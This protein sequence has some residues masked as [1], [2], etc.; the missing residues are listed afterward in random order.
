MNKL[1]VLLFSLCLLGLTLPQDAVRASTLRGFGS[2]QASALPAGAGMKF[3]CDSPAHAVLLIHKLA[4]D[5]ALSATVPSHWTMVSVGGASVPVLVRPGLGAYLVL[6]QG[7][8]AYCF[9]APLNAGQTEDGLAAAF[10]G[11]APLVPGAQLYDASYTYP[12]YLDKWTDKGIGTW[13]IPDDPFGDD[14]PELKDIINPH[15]Q[16][17]TKN[18]L[19]VHMGDGTRGVTMH[20]IRKYNRPYHFARWLRWDDDI[21]RL[22]PFELALPG[23]WFTSTSDYYG[24]VSNSGTKLQQYRNW[25]FQN[26]MT[27]YVNDPNLVDWDEPHGEFSVGG[28]QANG[29][30]SESS[31]LTFVHWL[32]TK[33]G[34]TLASLGQAWHHDPHFFA[35][36]SRVPLPNDYSLFGAEPDSVFSDHTWRIHSADVPTGVAAGFARSTFDDRRWFSLQLPGGEVGGLFRYIY[37]P[38]WYR[39]TITVTPAYLAAHKNA[40][41]L[42]IASLTEAQGPKSPDQVWFNGVDLGGMSGPGGSGITGTKDVTGIVHAGVNHIAYKPARDYMAGTFFLASKPMDRYPHRDSGVNARSVDWS[43]YLTDKAVDQDEDTLK[44]IRGTDP[45]RPIKSMAT[46]DKSAY[47]PMLADYA[48]FGHNTGDEAFFFPW[49]KRFGYPYGMHASAESSG[50]MVD[51]VAYNR[52]F[53]WFIFSG[54]NAFDNFIDVEAMMYTKVT[55][56]WQQNFPYLHL[57]NRYNL[58]K[59]AIGLLWSGSNSR[60][61]S[62]ESGSTP[63]VF[64]LGRGDLESIGYSYAYLDE[65]GLKRHLAD[66]YK[67]LWDCSTN[68]M[69]CETVSDLRHYVEQGGTF[70]ALQ[71]TGRNTPTE[72]DAWPIEAL[73]GFHVKQIRPMGGF[74]SILPDQ[75]L[76]KTL[77]GQNFQNEGRSTDYSGYNFADKCL[78]LEPVVPGTQVIARYRDGAIAIGMRKLGKGRVIV[79]GSP[80]WRDSY[81][82]AGMWWPG[83]GQNA[84]LQDLLTGLGLPP[85]VPADTQKV[86]RDRYIANNGTEEYLLL[87]N[88]DDKAPQTLTADWN[89][90]FPLTQVFDPKTGTVVAAKIDGSTAHVT[91]TLQPL[92]TKILAVQS[93]AAPVGT[94]SAWYTDLAVTWRQSRPGRTVTYPK[95]LPVYYADFSAAGGKVVEE[96]SVTP[97]R[98]TTLT[99]NPD[100]ETGWDPALDNTRPQPAEIPITPTQTALDRYA[101]TVPPSWQPGDTYYLRA[102]N[103]GKQAYL[104]GKPVPDG[105]EN[106]R[107][108]SS[109]LNFTGPNTLVIDTNV[110]AY[111]GGASLW[112]QPHAVSKLSLAGPWNVW[113]DE[114]HGLVKTPLPGSFNG[115][116]ATRTITVPAAWRSSHVF[117]RLKW[118]GGAQPG[119]LAVNSKVLFFDTDRPG[120]MDV[121]PWLKFGGPNTFLIQSRS[122]NDWQPGKVTILSAQLEQVPHV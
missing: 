67:V 117:L 38:L 43:D 21:A 41:S 108:V 5:M 97:E 122:M 78:A 10:A 13:Y 93:T 96:A 118:D 103:I 25:D 22:D 77:A 113:V 54:L 48:A 106:G 61:P 89:A 62:G 33:R 70:V 95:G 58:K 56:L 79:L 35:D 4:H 24:Q 37:K 75:P 15:F 57:A 91:E 121:T 46:G 36:W 65:T 76:F 20:Y 49:D 2:V 81:D 12:F 51:P 34:Y 116:L 112:R 40:V 50:S 120:Y 88:P 69:P 102:G 9:T 74:V 119:Y 92:E 73:T 14:P 109:L 66:S 64:D 105:D 27:P 68:V 115:M 45:N 111:N 52:W 6:A 39:G 85:D 100:S 1:K 47:F 63:F 98:L 84:F 29:D 114:D 107:D 17:L 110:G 11:A 80:F 42:I 71:E 86:W 23:K 99:T 101:V 94:V 28:M 87:F 90:S 104:N 32:Q 3:A 83:D 72:K 60:N 31:R 59:P 26:V 19:T 30:N 44:T 82:R 16:Y 18:G 8:D 53:G 55:P 7:S